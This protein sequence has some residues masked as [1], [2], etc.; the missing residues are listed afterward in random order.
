MTENGNVI[1]RNRRHLLKTTETFHPQVD[2][3]EDAPMGIQQSE[4]DD[5]RASDEGH[6]CDNATGDVCGSDRDFMD[7]TRVVPH[8]PVQLRRSDLHST[9][10]TDGSTKPIAR[11]CGAPEMDQPS[12]GL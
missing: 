2:G 4:E 10:D 12:Q 7:T 6:C 1:R 9:T 5:M 11:W 8:T 3:G